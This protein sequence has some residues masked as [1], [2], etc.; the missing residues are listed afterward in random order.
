MANE[1]P[2]K[3]QRESNDN[4]NTNSMNG[5]TVFGGR[6]TQWFTKNGGFTPLNLFIGAF[7][8]IC[9]VFVNNWSEAIKKAEERQFQAI[10]SIVTPAAH[11]V[12]EISPLP[13]LVQLDATDS[14]KNARAKKAKIHVAEF[15]A[16]Y[17]G[18]VALVFDETLEDRSVHLRDTLKKWSGKVDTSS[19]FADKVRSQLDQLATVVRCRS[20]YVKQSPFSAIRFHIF[21]YPDHCRNPG[22][23]PE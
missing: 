12:S 20:N 4:S 8:F 18:E 23:Q 21:G 16:A 7:A 3:Q 11:F 22:K 19:G 2:G 9:T 5:V 13:N 10:R 15:E 1:Q 14:E 17:W 6:I